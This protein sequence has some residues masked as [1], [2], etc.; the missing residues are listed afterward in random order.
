MN[1]FLDFHQFSDLHELYPNFI[2]IFFGFIFSAR[3]WRVHAKRN[4]ADSP[5]EVIV[6]FGH[7]AR[8]WDCCIHNSVSLIT[9]YNFGLPCQ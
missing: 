2:F 9:C 1:L 3:I 5:G 8:V 6:M 7:N 4:D